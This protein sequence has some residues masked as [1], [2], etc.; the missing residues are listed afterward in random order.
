M[1]IYI[2]IYMTYESYVHI[3]I[4]AHLNIIMDACSCLVFDKTH[5][6]ILVIYGI[7]HF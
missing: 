4:H 3:Q 7:F 1:K 2:Y 5:T 6:A